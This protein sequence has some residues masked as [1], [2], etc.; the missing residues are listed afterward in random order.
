MGLRSSF[1]TLMFKEK[2]ALYYKS[3]KLLVFI[4]RD[5]LI[6]NCDYIEEHN[7]LQDHK[8]ILCSS[9]SFF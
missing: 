9:S 2:G 6:Y 1:D 3:T 4:V 7:S 8:L 5:S